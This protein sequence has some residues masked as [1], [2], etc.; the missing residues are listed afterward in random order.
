[1]G[2]HALE[3]E[4]WDLWLQE[5]YPDLEEDV[6]KTQLLKLTLLNQAYNLIAARY[7]SASYIGMRN[8]VYLVLGFL[9]WAIFVG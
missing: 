3:R 8:G 6:Q 7:L 4:G 5:R 9:M 2:E 1:M